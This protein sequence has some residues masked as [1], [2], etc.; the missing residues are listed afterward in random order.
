[1][2]VQDTRPNNFILDATNREAMKARADAHP[3]KFLP[4]KVIAIK[5]AQT[6]FKNTYESYIAFWSLS[7][8]VRF[9]VVEK[10]LSF[11][12]APS[13]TVAPAPSI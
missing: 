7:E 10:F 6:F 4:G 12:S 1:M 9:S 5:T 2:Q 11:S 13:L 3:H 8:E